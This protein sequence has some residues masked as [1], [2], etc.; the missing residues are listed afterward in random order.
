MAW[1]RTGT[2]SKEVRR[3]GIGS[4]LERG[5]DRCLFLGGRSSNSLGHWVEFPPGVEGSVDP[6]RRCDLEDAG[7]VRAFL[8][9]GSHPR[10]DIPGQERDV[11]V[12]TVWNL[13]VCRQ[14]MP[15]DLAYEMTKVIFEHKTDLRTAYR[16]EGFLSLESQDPGLSGISFHPGA[17]RYFKEKGVALR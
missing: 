11:T 14:G 3:F 4:G 1:S 17:L 2:P 8:C 15:E 7:K 6:S 13:L 10:K 12:A 16:G 9:E 5:K